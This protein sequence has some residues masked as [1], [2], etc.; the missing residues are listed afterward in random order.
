MMVIEISIISPCTS[1]TGNTR[2]LVMKH[3]LLSFS[4]A[5]DDMGEIFLRVLDS[6]K[7]FLFWNNIDIGE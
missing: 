5:M 4:F 7:L 2:H 1:C 3:D 6:T